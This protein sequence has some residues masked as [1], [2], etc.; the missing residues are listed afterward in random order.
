MRRPAFLLLVAALLAAVTATTALADV[1]DPSG[2]SC[3]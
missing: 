1:R 2:R 3:G